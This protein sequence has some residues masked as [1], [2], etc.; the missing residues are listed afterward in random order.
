MTTL[1]N[2]LQLTDGQPLTAAQLAAIE[3]LAEQRI[4]GWW[5]RIDQNPCYPASDAEAV[6][7]VNAV[8]YL[9]T[10]E[11]LVR[12]CDVGAFTG[13]AINNGQRQ[14]S[15][16][17]IARLGLFLESRRSWRAGSELH[18]AKKT[19]AELALEN[20]R[21]TGESHALF[22]DLEQFDLR[23]LLLMLAESDNRMQREILYV[24]VQIKL[25]SYCITI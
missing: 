1:I 13:V 17:N 7:L 22:N 6:A 9:I 23:A 19:A 12:F 2:A 3:R 4:A 18:E 10:V 16:R 11:E 25:D 15:P 8:D 21:L 14:W 20:V 5:D 24:A